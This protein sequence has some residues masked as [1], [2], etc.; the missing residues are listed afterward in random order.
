VIWTFPGASI[1]RRKNGFVCQL[2]P[3][4]GRIGVRRRSRAATLRSVSALA[5]I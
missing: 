4:T 1:A 5:P 2:V 3:V